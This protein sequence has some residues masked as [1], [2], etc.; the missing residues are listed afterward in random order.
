MN[1]KVAEQAVKYVYGVD[2]RQLRFVA[3]RLG[4]KM[5]PTPL[6]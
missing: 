5:P 3:N 6:G 4:K 2:D 1:N